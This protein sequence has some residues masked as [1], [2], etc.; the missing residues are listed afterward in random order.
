MFAELGQNFAIFS[1]NQK[2]SQ[3]LGVSLIAIYKSLSS[4]VCEIIDLCSSG[5]VHS[6]RTF[7]NALVLNFW[8]KPQ[9]QT[10][11]GVP[12]N[13]V[14]YCNMLGEHAFYFLLSDFKEV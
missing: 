10:L 7:P 4:E 2:L 12:P 3:L 6:E 1:K 11:I 8:N 13:L 5:K 14:L 9:K